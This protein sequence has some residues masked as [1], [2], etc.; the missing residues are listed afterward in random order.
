MSE[1]SP[2]LR[3]EIDDQVAEAFDAYLA[4][5][6]LARRRRRAWPVLVAMALGVIATGLAPGAAWAIWFAV[7][8][9]AWVVCRSLS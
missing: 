8:V 3:D 6:G 1:L 4:E 5:S 9:T 7:A 2:R